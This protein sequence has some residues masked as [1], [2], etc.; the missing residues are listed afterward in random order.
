MKEHR[1]PFRRRY[2]TDGYSA[3]QRDRITCTVC[4]AFTTVPRG[5][6]FPLTA[7]HIDHRCGDPQW[8]VPEYIPAG[9]RQRRVRMPEEATAHA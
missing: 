1:P 4:G 2:I 5:Q 6:T 8:T 9:R 3:E 7:A